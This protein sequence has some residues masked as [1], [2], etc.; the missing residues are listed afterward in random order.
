M[1]T[2]MVFLMSLLAFG[3]VAKADEVQTTPAPKT[4]A[5]AL[6]FS[7]DAEYYGFAN[8]LFVV[9]PTVEFKLFEVLDASV[10]LP[11]YNNTTETGIGD[12]KFAA[13]YGLLQTKTGFFGADSSTLSVGAEV[14][15]PLDGAFASDS[16]NVTANLAFGMNWGKFAFNQ[17]GSYLFDSTGDVYVPVFGGFVGGDVISGNSTLSYAVTDSLKVGVLFSQ[18][19]TDSTKYLSVGPSVNWNISHNAVLD[20]SVGFPVEQQ[21]MLYGDCDYTVSAGLGFK[22]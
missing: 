22:F 3:G 1:K 21:D 17:T 15:V 9:N 12:L 13:N 7:A 6:D 8:K 2:A 20:V 19:Y 16:T 14:G 11:V 5:F 4:D 10:A 18:N